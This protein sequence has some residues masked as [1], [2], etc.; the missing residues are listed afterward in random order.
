[1]IR[2][3]FF[4]AGIIL[5][6]YLILQLGSHT[7]FSVILGLKWNLLWVTLIYSGSELVRAVALWKSLPEGE[8]QPYLKM[9][10]TRLSGE[11]IR[12]LTFTGPFVGEP[13]K[14]WLLHKIGVP[15]AGAFA[16]VITEYLMYTFASAA[17]GIAGLSYMLA[18]VEL[19]ND[20]VLVARVIAYSM[21]C[22]LLVA[23]IAI[24]FR[25]YLIGGIIEGIRKLPH[26]GKRV[27][28][29]RAEIHGMEELLFKV[30]RDHPTR[31]A[32]ILGFDTVAHILLILELYLIIRWSGIP[33]GVFQAFLIEASTKF[34]ALAFFFIP[35]QV[36]VAEKTYSV[37]FEALSLPV[38]IAVAMS[39]VRRLRTIVFSAVGL[40]ALTRLTR[41]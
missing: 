25:I 38:A 26:V 1:M 19:E 24:I 37:V 18:H 30:F 15:T 11:A 13:L 17:I 16:A 28:W 34:M 14:A 36:G 41:S 4:I 35:M 39:L 40:V 10:G 21:A 7:I 20:V 33:I 27:P 29:D 8:S 22:F 31:F 2:L 6:I 12:S 9:L 23:A 32:T 3:A 5:L